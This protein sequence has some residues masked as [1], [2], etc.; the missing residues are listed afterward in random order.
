MTGDDIG[1]KVLGPGLFPEQ[2][3]STSVRWRQLKVKGE[4]LR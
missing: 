4:G 1:R 3:G 2:G